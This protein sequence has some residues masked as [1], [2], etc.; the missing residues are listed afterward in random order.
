MKIFSDSYY[1]IPY[2]GGDKQKQHFKWIE[3]I[4]EMNT[5]QPYSVLKYT[6]Y[7]EKQIGS[8]LGWFMLIWTKNNIKVTHC[9]T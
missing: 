4:G 6:Q 7:D 9:A 1:E 8:S 2:D 5:T 3:M